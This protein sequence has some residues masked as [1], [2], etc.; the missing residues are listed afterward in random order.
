M[1]FAPK[2]WYFVFNFVSLLLIKFI[3][4]MPLNFT[5]PIDKVIFFYTF[6]FVA[7]WSSPLCVVP[8][9]NIIPRAPAWIICQHPIVWFSW[10]D[11]GQPNSD[12]CLL[13]R[14][15]FTRLNSGF[16]T[17]ICGIFL[18]T[19]LSHR[20]PVW[21]KAKQTANGGWYVTTQFRCQEEY[22]SCFPPPCYV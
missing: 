18:V 21:W 17:W 16:K 19:I 11:L 5:R 9:D 10:K 2:C 13:K 7:T 6:W 12:V 22:F 15:N 20:F 8:C 14:P 4:N 3:W 1:S